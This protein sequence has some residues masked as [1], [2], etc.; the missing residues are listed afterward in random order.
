MN[1]EI[2]KADPTGNSTI[3][4]LSPVPAEERDRVSSRLMAAEGGWAEQVGFVSGGAEAPRLDMMGGEFCGNASLSL[5]ENETA[6]SVSGAPGLVRCAVRR[7]GDGWEGTVS[8]PLPL[9]VGQEHMEL[10]GRDEVLWLVRLPGIIHAIAPYRS[11]DKAAALR[12]AR[13]WAPAT[14]AEAL[15]ILLFDEQESAMEPLVYVSAA[16]SAVWEHGCASGTAAIGAYLAVRDGGEASLD[17]YQPG[18]AIGV[19]ARAE[20][21]RVTQLS[22]SG[23]VRL[24][25]RSVVAV[26]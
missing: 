26:D 14:G 12:A 5:E 9:A 21:G 8:M 18:G 10:A 16:G 17:V 15:G 11:M 2:M 24:L 7:R 6:L 3:L 20:N 13:E 4:V 19:M 25:G 1:V 22:I 23:G